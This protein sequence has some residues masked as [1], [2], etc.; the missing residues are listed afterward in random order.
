MRKVYVSSVGHRDCDPYITFVGTDADSLVR[1]VETEMAEEYE[2]ILDG[3]YDPDNPDAEIE[4]TTV[5][6]GVSSDSL[7]TVARWLRWTHG[8]EWHWRL[9]ELRD[10]VIAF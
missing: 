6:Y 5:W 7:L 9:R 10:G 1:A 3:M 4:D 8:K 2:R